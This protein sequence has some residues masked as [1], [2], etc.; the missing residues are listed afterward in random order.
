MSESSGFDVNKVVDD[1]K[2]DRQLAI[3]V[4][5]FAVLIISLFL[6][7]YEV[8]AFGF[9]AGSVS[10]GLDGPGLLLVILSVLGAGAALNVMN[11]D[12]RTM[13]IATL[14]IAVLAALRVLT[15]YP[16]SELGAVVD[17]SF[18]YW[19][20]LAAPIVAGVFAGMKLQGKKPAAPKSEE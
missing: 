7:W 8:G 17:V 12:R 4:G 15:E 18:G 11:Q 16:D 19:L 2:K 9:S 14:V 20:S 1:L 10:P 6:P 3:I 13:W 5:S